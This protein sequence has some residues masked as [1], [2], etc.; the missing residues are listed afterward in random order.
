M[1]GWF[2]KRKANF[3]YSN[4]EVRMGL[5]SLEV[6]CFMRWFEDYQGRMLDQSEVE[7]IIDRFLT[8]E[9]VEHTTLARSLNKDDV[10]LIYIMSLGYSLDKV[11]EVRRNTDWDNR[12]DGF[13][14]HF[15][16]S[17]TDDKKLT[18]N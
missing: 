18:F 5:I 2:E 16:I 8:V 7:E 13:L 17:I 12:V 10:S 11:N 1:F 14:T 6:S 3:T 15:G 9:Q 4:E